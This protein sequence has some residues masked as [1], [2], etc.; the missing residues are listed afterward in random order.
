MHPSL[1]MN[2]TDNPFYRNYIFTKDDLARVPVKLWEHPLLIF[3]PTY[4]QMGDG[5]NFYYKTTGDGRIF[6]TKIEKQ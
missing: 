6:I 3:R 5:Y 4:V 1:A 2:N